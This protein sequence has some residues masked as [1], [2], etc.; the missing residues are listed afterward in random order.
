MKQLCMCGDGD[1]KLFGDV[2]LFRNLFL[3][4]ITILQSV[5]IVLYEEFCDH[6]YGG[7]QG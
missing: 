5:V 2:N 3:M 1:E 7:C 4:S 6:G